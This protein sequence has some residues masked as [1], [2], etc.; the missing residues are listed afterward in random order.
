MTGGF[1]QPHI[2]RDHRLVELVAKK[3][4]EVFS[5]LL[6]EIG[7]LVVHGEDDAFELE[8]RIKGRCTRPMVPAAR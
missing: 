3:I 2:A 4:F 6:C 8:L 7:A 5:D 1:G